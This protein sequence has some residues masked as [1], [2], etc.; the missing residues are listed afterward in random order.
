[1]SLNGETADGLVTLPCGLVAS[2]KGDVAGAIY[3]AYTQGVNVN[4]GGIGY[5]Y[6]GFGQSTAGSGTGVQAIGV[7]A[8]A[9]ANTGIEIAVQALP[10]TTGSRGFSIYTTNGH[11]HYNNGVSY[12][13]IGTTIAAAATTTHI[14]P[15]TNDGSVYIE[16]LLEVDAMIYADGGLSLATGAMLQIG[17]FSDATRGAPGT[18]GRLIFNTDDNQLNLDDGTNWMLMFGAA[19]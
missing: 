18:P 17:I 19:T 3:G 12:H 1:M 10:Y 9:K 4:T 13:Y 16:N 11:N 8:F 15:G 14:T 5:G 7:S 2:V 6:H